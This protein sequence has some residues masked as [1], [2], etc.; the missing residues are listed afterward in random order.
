MFS[1]HLEAFANTFLPA[2]GRFDWHKH[3]DVDEIMI[4]LSGKGTIEFES[5]EKFQFSPRDLVY[6]PKGSRHTVLS[7][8]T[9]TEYFFIRIE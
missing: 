3:D 7:S 8:S 1:P 5:G 9:P 4:C 6:I 2:N